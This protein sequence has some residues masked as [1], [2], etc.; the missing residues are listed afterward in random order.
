MPNRNYDLEDRFVDF[1]VR[2]ISVVEALPG[3]AKKNSS[4]NIPCWTLDIPVQRSPS[5]AQ[6]RL[7][8]VRGHGHGHVIQKVLG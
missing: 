8:D 2:I 6:R 7:T 1:A 4:F 5:C 3:N